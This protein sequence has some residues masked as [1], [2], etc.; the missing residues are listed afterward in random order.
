[1]RDDAAFA[2][3]IRRLHYVQGDYG[4]TR[5]MATA[6]GVGGASAPLFYMAIPPS[7]FAGGTCTALAATA[8]G[9]GARVV[10]EKPF[11]RDLDSAR[12]LNRILHDYFRSRSI[13]RIDHY[14]GKEPVQNIAYTRFAN[15]LFEPI[16]DR[17]HVRCIQITMAEEFGVRERGGFYEEAG[18]IRDVLQNHL[19]ELLAMVTMDPPGGGDPDALRSEKSR[20]LKAIRP[21]EPQNVVR[22]QYEGYRS[23]PGVAPDSTVETYRGREA[24]HRQLAVGRGAHL[25]THRQ[26]HGGELPPR[27]WWSS[28]CPRATPSENQSTPAAATCAY[29]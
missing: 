9:Q 6:R 11:G 20:L 24:G 15:S 2:E 7:V 17:H 23:A 13:F 22:G 12:N 21:L 19:L 28:A 26:S 10:V 3:L 1:M 4:T 16:W 29:A 25:H 18:A 27:C 14:L 5:P 8:C